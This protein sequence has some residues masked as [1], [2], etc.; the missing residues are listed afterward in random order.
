MPL[1]LH[2]CPIMWMKIGPHPCWQVQKALDEAGVEYE[3]VKGPLSRS[4]RDQIVAL[5][6]QSLYPVIEF[7]DGRVYREESKNMV[8]RIR[9]GKLSEA[10]AT[11]E[12]AS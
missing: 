12:A 11:R 6:G 2:R 8:K 7:E 4:K 10:T 1:K 3:L 5:S 9:A